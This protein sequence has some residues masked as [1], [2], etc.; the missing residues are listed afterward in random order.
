MSDRQTKKT[1]SQLKKLIASCL[2]HIWKLHGS[3]RQKALRCQFINP[4]MM[5]ATPEQICLFPSMRYTYT[6]WLASTELGRETVYS[7][8]NTNLEHQFWRHQKSTAW[9]KRPCRTCWCAPHLLASVCRRRKKHL[10]TW[11]LLHWNREEEHNYD[12]GRQTRTSSFL[13]LNTHICISC[14]HLTYNSKLLP[15]LYQFISCLFS[16]EG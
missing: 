12:G 15:V 13:R 8:T 4:S 1:R 6:S 2:V 16:V 5:F 14:T 11:D 7:F 3:V 9:D 10:E